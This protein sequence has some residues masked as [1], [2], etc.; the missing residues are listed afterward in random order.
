MV[1]SGN[2]AS[3]TCAHIY[4][5]ASDVIGPC[6]M[7][8]ENPRHISG[9]DYAGDMWVTMRY[10]YGREFDSLQKVGRLYYTGTGS[11]S[12]DDQYLYAWTVNGV[13][14]VRFS[15][16]W[17]DHRIPTLWLTNGRV[18]LTPDGRLVVGVAAGRVIAIELD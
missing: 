9:V 6:K 5:S 1:I 10:V 12:P 15:D 8:S 13:D 16:G 3:N 18:H 7:F 17:V 14:V 4:D 11:L 2:F